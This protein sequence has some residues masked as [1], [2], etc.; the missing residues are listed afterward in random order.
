[1]TGF[2]AIA[3]NR[4]PLSVHLGLRLKV[5]H[6][7]RDS[8]TLDRFDSIHSGLYLEKSNNIVPIDRKDSRTKLDG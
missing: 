2:E 8:A 4:S 7:I 1:M 5:R 6:S 3:S